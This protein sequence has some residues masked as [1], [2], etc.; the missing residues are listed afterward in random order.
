MCIRDSPDAGVIAYADRGLPDGA[1]FC[2]RV[3]ATSRYLVNGQ[4]T[5]SDWSTPVTANT[6]PEPPP[7]QCSA[8]VHEWVDMTNGTALSLGDDAAATV[9]LPFSFPLYGVAV[10]SAQV[11]S[12][13]FV[14]FTGGA[15]TEYVNSALPSASE[16]NGLVAVFWDDLDPSSTGRISY[17]T[18]GTA[19]AR[20]FAIA[21][22]GVAHFNAQGNPITVQLVL[23]ESSGNL[24][25]NYR[26]V[27]T[28]SI[29]YDAGASATIGIENGTGQRGTQIGFNQPVLSDLSTYRCGTSLAQPPAVPS[30]LAASAAGTTAIDVRWGDVAGET[31]YVLEISGGGVIEVVLPAGTTSYSHTGLAPA[32]QR[33]YRIRAQNDAGFSAFSSTV[34]ATTVG[35]LPATPGN[36]SAVGTNANTITVSW[37]D[38]ADETGYTVERT[39]ATGVVS[40]VNLAAGT[41][42]YRHTR[43]VPG[44]LWTYRV[45]ASNA[46]G[47]SAWSTPVSAALQSPPAAPSAAVVTQT[48]P[49]AVT[50]SWLD[51]SSNETS[52]E[53]GRATYDARRLR[54]GGLQVVTSSASRAG[55]GSTL[56]VNHA[57]GVAGTYRF[58]VRAVNAQGA[59]AW[60][61]NTAQV[62][63]TP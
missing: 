62:V 18:V 40:T 23:D 45:R 38:V 16:P 10:N 3:R 53:I 28:G 54:W 19:P 1:A 43:L 56:T 36:V 11:S 17:A 2:Y 5:A 61:N 9:S 25:L 31:A 29:S 27:Q 48:S 44:E 4:P 22:E 59:S 57:P 55:T 42:Q 49:A 34:S 24:T 12:N 8:Q 60:S 50:V 33:S 51:N 58:A 30:G 35:T 63:I 15:A 39:S 47:A 32:T 37:S 20:R 6:L 7:Y 52:F 26:D 41:V 21:W 46:A 13:G 14:R